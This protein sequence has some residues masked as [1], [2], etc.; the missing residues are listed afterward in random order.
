MEHGR[1]RR[2]TGKEPLLLPLPHD[3]AAVHVQLECNNALGQTPRGKVEWHPDV[4]YQFFHVAVTRELGVQHGWRLRAFQHN[5]VLTRVPHQF[6]FLA[7]VCQLKQVGVLPFV[8]LG[9]RK[10]VVDKK[11]DDIMRSFLHGQF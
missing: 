9:A 4:L 1:Q 6:V 2:L 11:R 10:P 7:H 5:G 3:R 8:Q